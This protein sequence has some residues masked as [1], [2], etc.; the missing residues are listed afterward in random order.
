MLDPKLIRE[1]ADLVRESLKKRGSAFDL[2][3]LIGIDEKRREL[4]RHVEAMKNRRNVTS[5]EIARLKKSGCEAKEQIEQL[6]AL[7]KE[8]E[9]GEQELKEVE[10][11]WELLSLEIP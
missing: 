6:R 3:K 11:A 7:G 10:R 1:K 2:E 4:I 5:D 8:I 9:T